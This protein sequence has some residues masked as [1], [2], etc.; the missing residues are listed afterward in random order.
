MTAF[1][2]VLIHAVPVRALTFSATDKTID[3]DRWNVR[4]TN[5]SMPAPIDVDFGLGG[6][7]GVKLEGKVILSTT[8]DFEIEFKQANPGV[9]EHGEIR[10]T[11]E[12][13]STAFLNENDWANISPSI[14]YIGGITFNKFLH[15]AADHR[16][17]VKGS[18][19][20]RA[21]YTVSSEG[22][23][24]ADYRGYANFTHIEPLEEGVDDLKVFVGASEKSD[25][26]VG[27]VNLGFG[28]LSIG[29]VGPVLNGTPEVFGGSLMEGRLIHDQFDSARDYQE[30]GEAFD[31]LHTCADAG[32]KGCFEGTSKH[33]LD[34]KYI[35]TMDAKLETF[36]IDVINVALTLGQG[37]DYKV[38]DGDSFHQSLTWNEPL[39]YTPCPHKVYRVPVAVWGN[40]DKTIPINGMTVKPSENVNVDQ[41]VRKYTQCVTG[42]DGR[43]AGK[44][45]LYLPFKEGRYTINAEGNNLQGSADQP[46]NMA[47]GLNT[48]VDIIVNSDQTVQHSVQKEWDIDLEHLDKP[49]SIE[50]VLQAQYYSS[51]RD[52][53]E[54]AKNSITGMLSWKT[55]Q[56]VTLNSANNWSATFDA[57]PEYEIINMEGDIPTLKKIKYRV[58]ELKP[59]QQKQP[60]EDVEGVFPVGDDS[61]LFENGEEVAID[62]VEQIP[63]DH[64]DPDPNLNEE[65]NELKTAGGRV[66]RSQFDLDNASVYASVKKH[67]GDWDQIWQADMSISFLRTLAKDA[68]FPV[69]TVVYK[70]PAYTTSVGERVKE[71]ETKYAVTYTTDGNAT[72]IK[73]TAIMDIAAYKRWIG[74]KDADNNDPND[75]RPKKP[76]SVYLL[77]QSRVKEKY[78]QL[79]GPEAE[80]FVGTYTPVLRPVYGS[81]IGLVGLITGLDIVDKLDLHGYLSIPLACGKAK[82][83]TLN[84]LVS[85]RVRF[86]VKKYGEL[87][88]PLEFEAGEVTSEVLKSAIKLVTGLDVP[89][90]FSLTGGGYVT[91]PG[92]AFNLFKDYELTSNVINTKINFDSSKA[93][94]GTKYWKNDKAE[95]RPDE[96]KIH[97]YDGNTELKDSKG[98]PV[99]VTV[100]KSEQGSGNSWVWSLTE[101]QVGVS[102]VFSSGKTYTIKEDVPKGYTAQVDGYNITNTKAVGGVTIRKEFERTEDKK[103]VRVKLTDDQGKEVGTY[104]LNE[105]NNFTVKITQKKD[106]A[107]AQGT[108]EADFTGHDLNKYKVEELDADKNGFKA[109]YTGPENETDSG[110]T[111]FVFTVTNRKQKSVTVHVEKEWKGDKEENRPKS[112]S[113]NLMQNGRKIGT[114]ELTS[115][116]GWKTDITKDSEGKPLPDLDESGAKYRYTCEEVSVSGYKC[117]ASVSEESGTGQA[118]G[119][120]VVKLVNEWTGG[121]DKVTVRGKKTWSDNNN[122]EGKR[123]GTITIHVCSGQGK[124]VDT[125]QVSSQDGTFEKSGLPRY[126]GDGNEIQYFVTED[127]VDGY[128]V[129][130]ENPSFDES[131]RVWTC[132]LTNSKDEGTIDGDQISCRVRKV[133]EDENNRYHTRPES[134]TVWLYQSGTEDAVA[135]AELN[136]EDG[137]VHEFEGLPSTDENG[138]EISYEVRED[139]VKGYTSSVQ[140]T[141]EGV[142]I[143]FTVTNTL[144][145]SFINVS[146]EKVWKDGDASF[147]PDS[148]QVH[149]LSDAEQAGEM[150]R[151]ENRSVTVDAGS[152]WKWTFENLDKDT[153]DGRE[154]VYSVEEDAVPGYRSEVSGSAAG[155]FVITNTAVTDIRIRKVWEDGDG[156]GRPSSVTASLYADGKFDSTCTLSAD[157]WTYTYQDLPLFDQDGN[158]IKYTAEEGYLNNYKSDVKMTLENQM[159]DSRLVTE[160]TLT[161]TTFAAKTFTVKVRKKITGDPRPENRKETFTFRAVTASSDTPLPSPSEVRITDEGE[162]S[163]TF[164]FDAEGVVAYSLQ[165]DAGNAEGYTYDTGNHVL[166]FRVVRGENGE[167]E[168]S[169]QTGDGAEIQNGG[170]VEFTNSYT[171]PKT[172][173]RVVKNWVEPEE[174]EIPAEGGSGQA[175]GGNGDASQDAAGE[176]QPNA[177]NAGDDVNA[178]EDAAFDDEVP[179]GESLS[180][181][182]GE[183]GSQAGGEPSGEGGAGGE[184]S[185]EYIGP[186][187]PE[188]VTVHLMRGTEEVAEA[189]LNENN[190]WEYVFTD[191]NYQDENGDII[192]YSVTEDAV[193]GY[194]SSIGD[195]Q[196]Q[197]GGGTESYICVI[198]NTWMSRKTEVPSVTKKV[199]EKN[200]RNGYESGWQDAADY[201]IGDEIPYRITGTLPLLF[202]KYKTYKVYTFEDELSAGLTPPDAA[203]ISVKKNGTTDLSGKFNITVRGQKIVI[204]LKEGEDMR[205]WTGDLEMKAGDTIVVEYTATLNERAVTGSKGN[206]NAV[207]LTFTKK[208]ENGEEGETETTPPDL[209]TVFT[210][211]IEAKKVTSDGSSLEGAGFTL[212]KKTGDDWTQVGTEI[213]GVTTFT[214]RGVDSGVYK[215]VETT[216][217][218]GYTKAEDIEISVT[219]SYDTEADIPQLKSLTVTP[220]SA[221]FAAEDDGVV[222]GDVVNLSGTVLPTTGGKGAGRYYAAGLL[223]MLCGALMLMYGRRRKDCGHG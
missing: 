158:R 161:N 72:T 123:P 162:A 134:V 59:K 79:A 192:P 44:A 202:H 189:V 77:V 74:F 218:P 71:H 173:F 75:T 21:V 51:G 175:A 76:D 186:V 7:N 167:L 153:A 17:K 187:R 90:S 19:E 14:P 43:G 125:I 196:S 109:T 124:T 146:G 166:I 156:S 151:V 215:L 103:E 106:G 213:T 204:S 88:L 84:P 223:L 9:F 78:R 47:R 200:D 193:E 143:T 35:W 85:W 179:D 149:L 170:A 96:I 181:D 92:K 157:D 3:D 135:L 64:F 33:I 63:A 132:N 102:G 99:V 42:Q 113:I 152:G 15:G 20:I 201:D 73:N 122:E 1:L 147:R 197:P 119:R 163:M 126:D 177:E 137:W 140:K 183:S 112:V 41:N 209:V 219:A 188:S 130:Y 148:I 13:Y 194:S 136:E 100:K 29:K 23:N 39:E 121:A 34:S 110:N 208:S 62:P 37:N 97:V 89:I 36:G 117:T 94:G 80:Q 25:I 56:I 67:F 58:R 216:V 53:Y 115:G 66:V 191:L 138:N 205:A 6:A 207:K 70:V 50:V 174:K 211:G 83:S 168:I 16:C 176:Q 93:I 91:I 198:T 160:F 221:G 81:T 120:V 220:A 150:K 60:E 142:P 40:N 203:D 212:F 178:A 68:L 199:K 30:E 214:F 32:K 172:T 48:Q 82:P 131:S 169:C 11:E 127:E 54:K 105:G 195:V 38:T 107:E 46:E 4:I 114:A 22:G 2:A 182:G 206:P 87:G 155:G 52:I 171:G 154:I 129:H 116:G 145:R 108:N 69:P 111:V 101:E 210:F 217:P 49:D 98:N 28:F 190:G 10:K 61:I 31:T 185:E 5:I 24:S 139:A 18:L 12:L 95:D 27:E 128:L 180:G 45:T 144:A 55:L 164:S 133:W 118:G 26:H 104:T 222:R 184:S 86:G 65:E 159:E 141:S 165:E 8:A 57:V